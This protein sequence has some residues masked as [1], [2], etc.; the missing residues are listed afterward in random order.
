M[1]ETTLKIFALHYNI[2]CVVVANFIQKQNH[3]VFSLPCNHVWNFINNRF[4]INSSDVRRRKRIKK[5]SNKD[6]KIKILFEQ[7]LNYF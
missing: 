3:N 4:Y 5:K 2:R 6:F 7:L 1:G